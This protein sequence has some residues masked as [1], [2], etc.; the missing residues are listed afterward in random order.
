MPA[1]T[2]DQVERQ[3]ERMTDRA[4]AAYMAG[5]MTGA[6]YKTRMAEIACWA[7]RE[8]RSAEIAQRVASRESL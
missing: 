3:V 4:D 5:K 1:L 8:S 7:D 6:E 2:E